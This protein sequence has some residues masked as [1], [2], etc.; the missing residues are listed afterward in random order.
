MHLCKLI[1]HKHKVGFYPSMRAR[2][3]GWTSDSFE[4]GEV[5]EVKDPVVNNNRNYPEKDLEVHGCGK[6]NHLYLYIL[7]IYALIYCFNLLMIIPTLQKNTITE[8]IYLTL[9]C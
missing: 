9:M 2:R 8:I 4:N 3:T 6:T 1:L 7:I 5:V